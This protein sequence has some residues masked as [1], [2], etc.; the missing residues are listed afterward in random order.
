MF[1]RV[2]GG[3]RVG[4]SPDGARL[5]VEGGVVRADVHREVGLQELLGLVPV[6]VSDEVYSRCVTMEG[7]CLLDG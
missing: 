3:V 1:G 7:Y 2:P 4:G 6:H 5:D